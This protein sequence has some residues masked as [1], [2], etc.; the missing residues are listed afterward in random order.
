[1]CAI[2]RR[3]H[4][5][6]TE[7][8]LLS[9]QRPKSYLKRLSSASSGCKRLS[10]SQT[11]VTFLWALFPTR[12]PWGL[13]SCPQPAWPSFGKNPALFYLRKIPPPLTADHPSLP[14]ARI[15]LFLMSPLSNFSPTLDPWLEIPACLTVF[16][17]EPQLSPTARV[18]TPISTV[19]TNL[20]YRRHK[21]Q[22]HFF[23]NRGQ[24]TFSWCLRRAWH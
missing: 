20:P 16:S 22:S 24:Q 6:P 17:V 18:R 4:T 12:P 10:P 19:P 13:P 14:L 7:A 15:P 23:F 8:L 5:E 1:M 3:P 11:S 9:A 21:H 2:T